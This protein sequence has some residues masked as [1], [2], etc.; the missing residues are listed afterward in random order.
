M[1]KLLQRLLPENIA[2]ELHTTAGLP[3]VSCDRTQL[4][5]VLL[6][7]C[8]NARD[9]MEH[10]GKLTVETDAVHFSAEDCEL[11]PW[12]RPGRFVRLS[13]TDT[14]AGMS[15]EVRERIFDPFFTTKAIGRGTGQGLAIAHAVVRK[16]GGILTFATEVGV[17]T[18]FTIR[19]PAGHDEG[20]PRARAA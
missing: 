14:G 6:N 8:V 4:E 2:F 19:L 12:A 15:P 10:G 20:A 18:T 1:Q 3:A 13:V 5:Q 7:L 9:A 16:H 17:G 11:N